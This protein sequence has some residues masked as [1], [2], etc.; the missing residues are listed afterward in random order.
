MISASLFL[1]VGFSV[2]G[3]IQSTYS[4]CDPATDPN[5]CESS[6]TDSGVVA[7]IN[8]AYEHPL[9]TAVVT[10][11]GWLTI[12][13]NLIV[14]AIGYVILT[15]IEMIIIPILQYNSFSSSP[16]IGL[17]WSLVRDVM[18]MFVIVAL[19]AIAVLTIVGN[20]K[21]HWEQQL[22]QLLIAVVLMNFSRTICGIFIDVSQVI[23]FTFVNALLDIA[24]GNFAQMFSLQSFGEL[25]P[26]AI[27]QAIDSGKGLDYVSNFV[28]AFIQIPL[29]GSIAAILFLL[30]LAFLYRIVLLWILVILS[31]MAFFMG[32]LKGIF[33]GAE[34]SAGDWWGKFTGALM[35]GPILTFF[36]WLALAAASGGS[37]AA[38]EGFQAP[39]TSSAYFSVEN[40]DSSKITSL[41]LALILLTVGMQVAGEQASKVGGVAASVINEG[42]GRKVVGGALRMSTAPIREG[43]GRAN[44]ALGSTF[45]AKSLT[46]AA[47]KGLVKA[48]AAVGSAPLGGMAGSLLTSAGGAVETFGATERK[49]RKE[50]AE[51]AYAAKSESQKMADF[52][53]MEA[54]KGSFSTEEHEAAKKSHLDAG[55]RKDREAYLVSKGMDATEAKNKVNDTLAS[56]LL[57]QFS[58]KDSLPEA[59]QTK[60][61]G[62]MSKNLDLVYDRDPKVA[63]KF[64]TSKDLDASKFKDKPAIFSHQ[65]LRP[66]LEDVTVDVTKDG[67]RISANDRARAGGYN[68]D[69]RDAANDVS[70]VGAESVLPSDPVPTVQAEK[71]AVAAK[72]VDAVMDAPMLKD[73]SG[74]DIKVD[75]AKMGVK[76]IPA[77]TPAATRPAVEAAANT[78]ARTAFYDVAKTRVKDTIVK[79]IDNGSVEVSK[80]QPSDVNISGAAG[81]PAFDAGMKMSTAFYESSAPVAA[82]TAPGSRAALLANLNSSAVRTNV[83]PETIAKAHVKF[84]QDGEPIGNALAIPGIASATPPTMSR[85]EQ[86]K[87]TQMA[88]IDI[89]TVRHLHTAVSGG[90]P[91]DVTAAVAKSVGSKRDVENL[92]EQI[93]K[94]TNVKKREEMK[95]GLEAARLAVQAESARRGISRKAKDRFDEV[96]NEIDVALSMV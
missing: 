6:T 24:A 71:R 51:K 53:M 77:N 45:G 90:A 88:K 92:R 73:A 52:D 32:G 13:L 26:I 22:P 7:Q 35:M 57:E 89:S 67:K 15:L 72:S 27:Q 78:A 20:H 95:K 36:L 3:G 9:D 44:I 18:N 83:A 94:E 49:G 60:L 68:K 25:N 93:R 70:F 87:V 1:V 19:I 59:E 96:D 56:T 11:I 54:G 63:A 16:I 38:S 40:L 66:I 2:F 81:T 10:L 80:I 8:T 41:L 28:S 76:T 74:K 47:G 14:S 61:F 37:M 46:E 42:M 29:Y 85:L 34:K 23:M 50:A 62:E 33:S 21:A 31:P 55:F 91:N 30:A 5:G 43:A 39:A 79:G 82:V 64:A 69:V 65:G 12:I 58:K 48:G 4:A 86:D 17:G 84:I 75:M